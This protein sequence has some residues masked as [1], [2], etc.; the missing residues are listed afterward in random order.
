MTFLAL[1]GLRKFPNPV[2][3]LFQFRYL[4]YTFR[5]LNGHIILGKGELMPLLFRR[6]LPLALG[7]HAFSSNSVF[8][9]A[10]EFFGDI[11]LGP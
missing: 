11:G 5:V 7:V 2:G 8:L 1:E 10:S 4:L 3:L 9:D 6:F